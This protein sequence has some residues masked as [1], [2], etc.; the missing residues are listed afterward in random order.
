MNITVRAADRGDVGLILGLIRELAEYEREPQA[1]VATEAL[2]ARALFGDG[3]Q[4]P[5]CAAAIGDVDG[6]PQ[7]F[8]L[9][10]TTFSTWVGRPGV[11]LEDL[12]VRPAARGC[13][14]GLAL[15]THVARIARARGGR[16]EW[17]VLNWNEP[18]IGF[19]T[20]LGARPMSGWT[21]YRLDGEAL[22][23]IE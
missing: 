9:Y 14:L 21:V 15:F 1:V 2:I 13:G 3:D 6:V 19:Y 20:K 7:G 12:F 11:Y 23:S 4:G 17:S 8:A 16:M 5:V 22:G 10:F 18:A